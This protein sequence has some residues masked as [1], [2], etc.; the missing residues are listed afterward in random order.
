MISEFLERDYKFMKTGHLKGYLHIEK[1]NQ[2]FFF[3]F[4]LLSLCFVE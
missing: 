1:N 3:L 4:L 2:L